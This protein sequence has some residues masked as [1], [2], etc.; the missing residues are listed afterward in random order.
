MTED[1]TKVLWSQALGHL[2]SVAPENQVLCPLRLQSM[3]GEGQNPSVRRALAGSPRT[4]AVR[5]NASDLFSCLACFQLLKVFSS[6]K[7]GEKF[8]LQILTTRY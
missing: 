7:L 4:P 1:P 8:T 5:I 6:N 3:G 2:F